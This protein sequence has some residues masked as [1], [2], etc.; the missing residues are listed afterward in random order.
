MSQQKRAFFIAGLS[1]LLGILACVGSATIDNISIVDMP[2]FI[3]PSSTPRATH[4]QPPTQVQPV[5]NIPPSGYATFTPVPG[6]SWNGS[7]C[8]TNTPYPG[9]IYSTPGYSVPGPTST[10]R[11]TLTPW[12]T[13]TPHTITGGFHLGADV[14]AGGF[15]SSVSIRLQIDNVRVYP[16]DDAQQVVVW[17]VEIENVGSVDYF[18]LPGAQ[19]FVAA[20]STQSGQW[21]ASEEAANAT[22]IVLQPELMDV[23]EVLPGDFYQL[24]L[25]AFTPLGDPTR[26]GWILDPASDGRDGDM[27]G[28]NVAYWVSETDPSC[29]GNIAPGSTP[30]TPVEPRPT[31]TPTHT[32]E[33]PT[34]CAWCREV[35]A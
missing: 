1:V 23:L 6:C 35:P 13:P 11:A 29:I 26:L 10:P 31:H 14:Y 8:A 33:Y 19:V 28:G 20:V 24:T 17:D 30:G 34:W 4:T 21:W 2:Q 5:T 22:G 25:T 9:G 27:I 16:V 32:P 15:D 3:C 12:P 18:A 7:F